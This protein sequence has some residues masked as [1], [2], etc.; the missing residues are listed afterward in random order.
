MGIDETPRITVQIPDFI[1]QDCSYMYN[2][3]GM[4]TIICTR[5]DNNF[6]VDA[7][8]FH[9]DKYVSDTTVTRPCPYCFKVSTF[10]GTP[11]AS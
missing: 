2:T 9:S 11:K 7:K 3:D 8:A 5:C 4:E 1:I 6:I 10:P